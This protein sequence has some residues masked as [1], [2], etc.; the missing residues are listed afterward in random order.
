MIR[1]EL[2]KDTV[3]GENNICCKVYGIDVYSWFSK[4]KSVKDITPDKK[5]LKA[6]IKL[7]NKCK[8]SVTHIDCVIEDFVN[9]Q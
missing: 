5:K 8:V 6:Q 4:I 7:W 9:G 3:N 2:R 1:Y